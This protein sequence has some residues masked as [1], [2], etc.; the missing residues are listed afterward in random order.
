MSKIEKRYYISPLRVN[1]K[2]SDSVVDGEFLTIND[3]R[4]VRLSRAPRGRNAFMRLR[5]F[6]NDNFRIVIYR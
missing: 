4:Y 3:L 1:A 5:S 6:T 2:I